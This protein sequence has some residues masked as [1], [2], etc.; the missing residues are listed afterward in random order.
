MRKSKSGSFVRD[1][2][3]V[4]LVLDRGDE[5]EDV[6]DKASEVIDLPKVPAGHHLTLLTTGGAIIPK[7]VDWTVGSYLRQMHK[8]PAQLRLG[9]GVI[10]KVGLL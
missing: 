4:E 8:A 1:G 2:V 3:A 9:I 10:K 5:Y 6:L 7:K